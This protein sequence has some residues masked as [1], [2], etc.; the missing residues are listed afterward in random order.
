MNRTRLHYLSIL[1]A[2]VVSSFGRTDG[3]VQGALGD[4]D[5]AGC[6]FGE[7][8]YAFVEIDIPSLDAAYHLLLWGYRDGWARLCANLAG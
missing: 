3:R 4:A 6:S 7:I 5:T 1:R 2:I 8:G